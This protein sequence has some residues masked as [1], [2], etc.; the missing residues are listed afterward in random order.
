M[1]LRRDRVGRRLGSAISDGRTA[2]GMFGVR[3]WLFAAFGM[4]A[5]AVAIGVPTVLIANPWFTRMTPVRPQDYLIWIGTAMLSGLLVGSFAVRRAERSGEGKALSAGALSM[6]AVA[7]P[8][9]NKLV[10]VLLGTAGA[11]TFF[12]PLQLYLGIAS[13]G[14]LAWSLRLRARAVA[15][16]CDVEPQ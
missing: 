10:V 16:A 12:A 3:A 13:L 14:L 5:T 11:L 2:L 9:C 7:C 6:F 8:V 15:G 1:L 4:I